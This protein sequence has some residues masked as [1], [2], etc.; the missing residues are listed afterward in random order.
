M[1]QPVRAVERE[2]DGRLRD[3]GGRRHVSDGDPGH[4]ARLQALRRSPLNRTL[5]RFSKAV[6]VGMLFA[7]GLAV[8]LRFYPSGSVYRS[9]VR[10]RRLG[11]RADQRRLDLGRPVVRGEAVLLLL[12]VSQLRVAE[13]LHRARLHHGRD[14][15]FVGAHKILLTA[16]LG[17]AP[18]G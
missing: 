18:S 11:E 6:Y 9:S 17:V 2:G 14:K 3:A 4:P 15:V 8:K 1:S 13:P 5:N 7:P 12:D 10:L 16:D